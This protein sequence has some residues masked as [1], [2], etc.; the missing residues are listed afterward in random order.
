MMELAIFIG[1]AIDAMRP[2]CWKNFRIGGTLCYSQEPL[3]HYPG[4][5]NC[6][7]LF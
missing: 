6:E 4:G 3:V 7:P 5:E 2:V 1:F